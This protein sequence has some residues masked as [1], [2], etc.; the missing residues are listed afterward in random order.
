VAKT[1][2]P[3]LRIESTHCAAI[4]EELGYRLSQYLKKEIPEIPPRL[5]PLFDR[6]RQQD[7]EKAPSIVPS[8]ESPD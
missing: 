7:R 1:L 4:S 8:F 5:K 2:L 6:L 3:S